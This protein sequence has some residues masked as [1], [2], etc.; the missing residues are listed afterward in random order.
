MKDTKKRWKS[1][2]DVVEGCEILCYFHHERL[3]ARIEVRKG[4]EHDGEPFYV[5]SGNLFGSQTVRV[6]SAED[7]LRLID[8]MD[9]KGANGHPMDLPA[10]CTLVEV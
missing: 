1:Q 6:E 2:P 7:A 3:S 8:L 5:T 4:R 9:R 10:G